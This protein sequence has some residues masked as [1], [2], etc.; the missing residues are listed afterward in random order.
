MGDL[1]LDLLKSDAHLPAGEFLNQ[2][3]TYAF[4]PHILQP[5]RITSHSATLIDHIYFNSLEYTTC[6]GN[7]VYPLTDHLPNFL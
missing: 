7:I 4:Q 1:N 2:L 6:S 5:T 3:S